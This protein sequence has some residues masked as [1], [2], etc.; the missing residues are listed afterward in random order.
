VEEAGA[1]AV[2]IADSGSEDSVAVVL[3]VGALAE[4][5][6]ALVVAAHPEGGERVI[7]RLFFPDTCQQLN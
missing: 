1:V 4:E 6:A 7:S 5:V 2:G 3:A